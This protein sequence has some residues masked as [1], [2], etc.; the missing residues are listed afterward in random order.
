MRGQES[1]PAVPLIAGAYVNNP[2]EGSG[3][4]RR[5]RVVDGYL[6]NNPHEGSGDWRDA[7]DVWL[8]GR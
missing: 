6:V 7:V 8:A 3:V 1:V 4:C 5:G 2:H